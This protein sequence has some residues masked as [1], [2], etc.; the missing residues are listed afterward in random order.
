[1]AREH[2]R[3]AMAAL[4]EV[5]DGAHRAALREAAASLTERAF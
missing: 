5:P 4:H 1:M 2:T 3:D